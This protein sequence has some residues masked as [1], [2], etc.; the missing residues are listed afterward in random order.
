METWTRVSAVLISSHR[1]QYLV[2]SS[3]RIRIR[4]PRIWV[5]LT[6]WLWMTSNRQTRSIVSWPRLPKCLL[7]CLIDSL[8]TRLSKLMSKESILLWILMRDKADISWGRRIRINC[9]T[10]ILTML[11]SWKHLTKSKTTSLYVLFITNNPNGGHLWFECYPSFA[12]VCICTAHCWYG[13]CLSSTLSLW[14][15]HWSTS[16]NCGYSLALLRWQS[17]A[18]IELLPS[19]DS[20]K[21]KTCDTIEQRMSS[22]S[23]ERWESA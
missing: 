6:F 23:E 19:C 15:S 11:I 1:H 3:S 21:P 8:I 12:W 13:K 9:R 4:P 5:S 17:T 2:T 22:L 14:Q 18:N 16:I 7:V 20:L 10:T